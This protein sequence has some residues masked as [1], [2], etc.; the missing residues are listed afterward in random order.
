[1]ILEHNHRKKVF[2]MTKIISLI[3]NF[4]NR[5]NKIIWKI[6]VF[7]SKFI[8]L[9]DI[10]QEDDIANIKYRRF[11]V[12]ETPPVV[13]AFVPIEH[14]DYKQ[15]IKDKNISPIKRRNGKTINIDV[16]CPCCGA[17]KDYLYD[18]NGKEYQFECKVCNF[19]F[20]RD[21]SPSK[22]KDVI[23][24]C[25]HCKCALGLKHAREDFDVYSCT[26]QKCSYYQKQLSTLSNK[27]KKI[28]KQNPSA[29][30]LH[31]TYRKYNITIDQLNDDFRKLT[32]APVDLSKIYFSDYI[33]GLCLTYH[34]NYGLSYRQTASIIN[35]I[36]EVKISYKTVE[37]YCK[38]VSPLVFPIV[39]YYPYE[40]SDEQAADE[41]YIK[42]KGKTHYIFFFFDAI[43]K[44]ITSY[45]VFA[46]RDTLSAIKA[47]HSALSKF[48]GIPDSLKLITDGNPI[49]NVA[50]EYWRQNGINFDL[51]QVIGL[52]NIDDISKEYR[53]QKQIIER[54]NRTLKYHYRPKGGFGS[55][56]DANN[57]M[58]LFAACFNFLRPHASLNYHVPV[59]IPEIQLLPN[60][61]AKWLTLINLSVKYL[62]NH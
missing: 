17:P 48:N 35:D 54:L 51:F 45:R 57:Y 26:N 9:D 31:Y 5:I 3:I 7:L 33:L 50:H 44:I 28:Y 24:K 58:V 20:T 27:D 6:I 19:I 62:T 23:I 30:T 2:V 21:Y 60:M 10:N 41:T 4:L 38:S 18:N 52:S 46:K 36:H 14:K 22:D 42:I 40:L 16:C 13:E 37:N 11:K 61:P 32:N 29:F 8:K 59:E 15:I 47:S 53:S 55:L 43:K 39:E 12:D 34:I 56:D 25:P 1:M 49:Y